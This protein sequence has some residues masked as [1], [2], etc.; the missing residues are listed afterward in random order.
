MIEAEY[1][2]ANDSLVCVPGVNDFVQVE[3]VN[4]ASVSVVWSG[5]DVTY[6]LETEA[7]PPTGMI[8][9]HNKY[10]ICCIIIN[11]NIVQL[12]CFGWSVFIMFISVILIIT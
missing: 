1:A 4:N 11:S 8:C 5:P 10:F 12:F 2:R 7:D 6:S 9:M 3:Y